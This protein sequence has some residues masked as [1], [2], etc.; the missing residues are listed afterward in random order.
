M[1]EI[2]NVHECLRNYYAPTRPKRNRD[3]TLPLLPLTDST[4]I[5][6]TTTRLHICLCKLL[7]L[8]D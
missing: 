1:L 8:H 7:P 5:I 6:F 3:S 4:T 2:V